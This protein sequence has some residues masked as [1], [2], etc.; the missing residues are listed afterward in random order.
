MRRW[1]PLIIALALIAAAC[2]GTAG[3][4]TVVDFT[5]IA[6]SEPTFTFDPSATTGRLDLETTIPTVCAIA[7]GETETLGVLSTDQ[8]MQGDG[9]TDHGP[10]LTG[11]K[12]E[13]T[14]FYRLQGVGPDGTLYQSELL[15]FTT[16]AAQEVDAGTNLALAATVVDVSSEFSDAFAAANAIDGNPATEWS[17]RGDGDDAYITV[18]LGAERTVTGLRFVTREMSDGSSITTTYTVRTPPAATRARSTSRSTE[19]ESPPSARPG[20]DPR[21]CYREERARTSRSRACSATVC[22]SPAP[23]PRGPAPW[24]TSWNPWRR[25]PTGP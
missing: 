16:P 18:D 3:G 4:G 22:C 10:V 9:H 6:A 19:A 14:Y 21:T 7:Y 2:G 25:S 13:T 12:P 5:E 8:D 20:G 15:T 24:R 11:L 17:S 1:T 23:L